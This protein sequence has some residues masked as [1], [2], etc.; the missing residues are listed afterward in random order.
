MLKI[1]DS[2]RW[3]LGSFNMETCKKVSGALNHHGFL[4]KSQSFIKLEPIIQI[5]LVR[6]VS[7]SEKSFWLN[8]LCQRVRFWSTWPKFLNFFFQKSAL[9][10]FRHFLF[11][12]VHTIYS[13]DFFIPEMDFVVFLQRNIWRRVNESLLLIP[14]LTRNHCCPLRSY[15]FSTL[16]LVRS[17]RRPSRNGGKFPNRFRLSPNVNRL[18]TQ[19]IF[20]ELR[21]SVGNT[22]LAGRRDNWNPFLYVHGGGSL[23]FTLPYKLFS[24]VKERKTVVGL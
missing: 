9:G 4:N 21:W 13:I 14:A 6:G 15:V 18:F 24:A 3:V 11:W 10:G 16:A 19:Q 17:N 22:T 5:L 23:R 12:Y 1:L 20:T 2:E 8:D 7:K